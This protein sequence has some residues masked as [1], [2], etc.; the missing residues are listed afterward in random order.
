MSNDD[1]SADSRQIAD[2]TSE[3]EPALEEAEEITTDLLF[4]QLDEMEQPAES[5]LP[6]I[7]VRTVFS[8]ASIGVVL[9]AVRSACYLSSVLA[10]ST[11]WE[12]FDPLALVTA[13]GRRKRAPI[14]SAIFVLLPTANPPKRTPNAPHNI[15]LSMGYARIAMKSSLGQASLMM[16]VVL[17]AHSLGLLTDRHMAQQMHRTGICESLAIHCSLAA[18]RENANDLKQIVNAVLR[19]NKD[20]ASVSI[21]QLG[22]PPLFQAGDA[23]LAEGS[24][25]S[26]VRATVPISLS[27]K[28]W[29]ALHV[30]FRSE[31]AGPLTWIGDD[32][33]IRLAAFVGTV[34]LVILT[35][36]NLRLFRSLT[37]SH[38]PTTI[39]ERVRETLDTFVEGILVLGNDRK[40]AF[41]NR[42][43]CSLAGETEDTL[44]GK[45]ASEL[46][47]HDV[48]NRAFPWDDA[49]PDP[50]RLP[51]ILGLLRNDHV[52]CSLAVHTSAI[53][54]DRGSVHGTL[55]TF[56]DLTTVERM[57]VRMRR[58]LAILRKSR[59][60]IRQKNNEL[61]RLATTDPLTQCLNRREFYARIES[62]LAAARRHGHSLSCV[63]VDVDRFKS[64]NDNHG[65]AMGDAVLVKV[66]ETLRNTARESDIVCR[67]G[68]EE[69]CVALAYTDLLAAQRAAER[70]R[71]AISELEVEGLSVTASL[72][73]S[74]LSLGPATV[75][76]MLEQADQ[77]LYVAKRTGRNRVVG[78]GEIVDL[79][80]AA[81]GSLA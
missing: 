75:A 63:M 73:V 31:H 9:W 11:A 22:K 69:F 42:A 65:H 76:Q 62:L 81:A 29:G 21:E 41:A 2:A 49:N 74:S 14:A 10:A 50:D 51:T 39:P 56:D 13:R 1:T 68:G 37:G 60:Q 54:D 77:V 27:D 52:G 38:A 59:A 26:T 64:I 23:E 58:L 48:E 17:M 12:T 43:F 79:E 55:A 78:F 44:E 67:Y 45:P 34:G 46:A 35:A 36:Y 3:P 40:I 5:S 4:R 30:V 61:H 15:R 32:P 19:R 24:H 53:R 66:A 20:I 8:S 57:N 80:S 71:Q 6:T 16:V 47:W 25:S 70:L 28:P 18:Q 7:T 72:G 33:A